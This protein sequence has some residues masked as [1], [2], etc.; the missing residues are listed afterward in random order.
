MPD[1]ATCIV[2]VL[3]GPTLWLVKGTFCLLYLQIFRPM[4]WLR[5]NIYIGVTIL[6]VFYWSF[7]IALF[8]ID[9]P[10]PWET[11]AELELS[12]RFEDSAKTKVPMA[13]GGMIADVWLLVLPLI[14]IYK[15]QLH[16]TRRIALTIMFSTGLMSVLP[17]QDER[18]AKSFVQSCRSLRSQ[19]LLPSQISVLRGSNMERSESNSSKVRQVIDPIMHAII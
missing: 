7:S 5:V 13:V 12:K 14:A 4:R 10:R 19:R 9:T 16:Q 2:T 15:L 8:V 1:Q 6:T 3:Y 18:C 17:I 11:W